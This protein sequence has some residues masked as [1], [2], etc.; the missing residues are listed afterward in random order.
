LRTILS[1]VV[2]IILFAEIEDSIA[3]LN[4]LEL[5]EIVWLRPEVVVKRRVGC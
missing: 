2:W 1:F 3:V 5:P 4:Q